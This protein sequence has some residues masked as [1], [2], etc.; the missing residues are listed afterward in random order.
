MVAC[1]D[2]TNQLR[3]LV[4]STSARRFS[5]LSST[6]DKRTA[7][8]KWTVEAR[9]IL[10]SIVNLNSF[11]K[12]IRRAYLDISNASI[13]QSSSSK[14]AASRYDTASIDSMGSAG[15]EKSPFNMWSKLKYLTDKER[16]EIDLTAKGMIRQLMQN[17]DML[18]AADQGRHSDSTQRP[19]KNAL[20]N[21]RISTIETIRRTEKQALYKKFERSSCV[22]SISSASVCDCIILA[23]YLGCSV[24]R[25]QG[26]AGNTHQAA[27]PAKS[28]SSSSRK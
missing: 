27:T 17:I 24:L 28:G 26:S 22:Q 3:E 7:T 9:K 25:T 16:D 14:R 2:Q 20:T 6:R 13:K 15:G 21:S 19:S 8:D 12:S 11:L 4:G 23:V 10:Q 1:Q 5:A 18:K